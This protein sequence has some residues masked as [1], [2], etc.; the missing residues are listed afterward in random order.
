MGFGISIFKHSRM[1]LSSL[2]LLVNEGVWRSNSG[3]NPLKNNNFPSRNKQNHS[4]P[5][6]SSLEESVAST[7][8]LTTAGK[9]RVK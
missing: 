1:T 5:T 9:G 7:K 3:S 6:Q 2:L 4:Q 8:A